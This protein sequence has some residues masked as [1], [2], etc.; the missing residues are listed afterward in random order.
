MIKKLFNF[1]LKWVDYMVLN[2]I[3]QMLLKEKKIL[4]R[5]W[6]IKIK[7]IT[8]TLILDRVRKFEVKY[9]RYRGLIQD[10]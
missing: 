9:Y 5:N 7:E 3:S 8:H 2:Y 4:L 10:I 6:N 1:T